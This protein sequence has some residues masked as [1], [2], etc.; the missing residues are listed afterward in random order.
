MRDSSILHRSPFEIKVTK[1]KQRAAGQ[2]WREKPPPPTAT[3]F[4]LTRNELQEMLDLPVRQ[5]KHGYAT[6][7]M[8]V[9]YAIERRE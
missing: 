3:A 8:P 1:F 5:F 6:A 9:R 7:A 2:H 4:P